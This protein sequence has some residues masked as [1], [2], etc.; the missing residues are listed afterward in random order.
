MVSSCLIWSE[1]LGN[2]DAL[3]RMRW[4][5]KFR[6]WR[7][8]IEMN[9]EKIFDENLVDNWKNI[10]LLGIGSP[11]E[12]RQLC[13]H[14]LQREWTTANYALSPRRGHQTMI[15]W[16]LKDFFFYW[17][18]NM[19]ASIVDLRKREH[20]D[21]LPPLSMISRDTRTREKSEN[22]ER[23]LSHIWQNGMFRTTTLM[24]GWTLA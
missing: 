7:F 12:S 20:I 10:P 2:T 18:K 13:C 19:I 23:L 9:I 24:Q 3:C 16:K 17:R 15:E 4:M 21:S 1:P 22:D 5:I 14:S 6:W 11:L 8:R